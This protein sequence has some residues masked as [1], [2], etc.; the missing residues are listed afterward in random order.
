M[1]ELTQGL[2]FNTLI[3]SNSE[4]EAYAEY[5]MEL[6]HGYGCHCLPDHAH[7]IF[8]GGQGRAQDSIDINC[9]LLRSCYACEEHHHPECDT[10]GSDYSY[11][12][13]RGVNVDKSITCTDPKDSCAREVCECDRTFAINAA[14][15]YSHNLWDDHHHGINFNRAEIC[16]PHSHGQ[17]PQVNHCD[18][19]YKQEAEIELDLDD[20]HTIHQ[21]THEE[22]HTHH[23]HNNHNHASTIHVNN[24]ASIELTITDITTMFMMTATSNS[25]RQPF[26]KDRPY[27]GVPYD[28]NGVHTCRMNCK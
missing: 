4:N 7:Y 26:T 9:Q 24:D 16:R 22:A 17:H 18:R 6:Y 12:L 2:S 1:G 14:I 19:K 25:T 20:H 23:H 5:T 11:N 13:N 8:T 3:T 10:H 27:I 28:S 21:H 15:L